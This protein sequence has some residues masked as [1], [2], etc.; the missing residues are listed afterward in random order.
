MA[1]PSEILH[2]NYEKPRRLL[3]L[4]NVLVNIHQFTKAFQFDSESLKQNRALLILHSPIHSN[5]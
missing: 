2:V 4:S 3:L 1:T 5:F